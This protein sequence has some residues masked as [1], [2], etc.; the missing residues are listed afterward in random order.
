MKKCALVI[1]GHI[2]NGLQ[3]ETWNKFIAKLSEKYDVDLFLQTWE[4]S[5]AMQSW[6]Y[7]DRSA[8]VSV[9]EEMLTD[10]FSYPIKKIRIDNE[11]SIP[12]YGRFVGNVGKTAMPFRGWKKMIAGMFLGVN[13]AKESDIKYNFIIRSRFDYFTRF[14]DEY[15]DH[16]FGPSKISVEYL[17]SQIEAQDKSD[18]CWLPP[19]LNHRGKIC[20][21]NFYFGNLN[22]IYQL[23]NFMYSKKIDLIIAENKN[24]FQEAHFFHAKQ[25]LD[26]ASPKIKTRYS[27]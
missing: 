20:I 26:S 5:E 25:Y 12:I 24:S 6:R 10:Y 15:I 3:T 18:I 21:D 23:L 14:S 9:T 11:S 22:S 19:Y 13:L 27:S 4:E 7:L 2:R 17:L 16:H 1:T 8:I